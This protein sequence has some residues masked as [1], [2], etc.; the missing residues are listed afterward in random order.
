MTAKEIREKENKQ[1]G[2]EEAARLYRL[3]LGQAAGGGLDVGGR[4]ELLLDLATAEYRCGNVRL[5]M[6]A[7]V[8]AADLARGCGR[9]S[10]LAGAPLIVQDIGD[11]EVNASVLRA[12]EGVLAGADGLDDAVRVRLLAQRAVALCE[13]GRLDEALPDS[14]RAMQLAERSGDP[15]LKAAV[16]PARHVALAGPD[17]TLERLD[18]AEQALGLARLAAAP[19]QEL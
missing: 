5:A 17:W 14:E 8:Q 19:I 15:E 1:L 10:L 6:E 12:C 7:F 18:L 3:A 2:H 9:P 16:L 11:P 13:S 4:C